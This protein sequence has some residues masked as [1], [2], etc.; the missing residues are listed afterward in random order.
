VLNAAA[1]NSVVERCGDDDEAKACWKAAKAMGPLHMPL[2]E[3]KAM[4]NAV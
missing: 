4:F 2:S 1:V 3:T